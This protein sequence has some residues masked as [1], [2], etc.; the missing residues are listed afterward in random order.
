MCGLFLWRLT[1]LCV[2]QGWVGEN[3][4]KGDRGP[5]GPDGPKGEKVPTYNIFIKKCIAYEL[6]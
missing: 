1:F 3:G 6:M 2:C 4:E 5:A